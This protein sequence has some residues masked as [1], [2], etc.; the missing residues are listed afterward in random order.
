[1]NIPKNLKYTKEHDWLE[2]L[3][4]G[5]YK[6]G[7]T[8]YAQEALGDIVY[9]ELP[10]IGEEITAGDTL[11]TVESVKAVSEIVIPCDC[12]VVDKNDELEE[13]PE[14]VNVSC[15]E[16]WMVILKIDDLKEVI[17]AEEYEKLI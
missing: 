17:S 6:M 2:D 14:K 11:L 13:E 4:E 1:M 15:Y 3:G 7:I 10:E 5:K 12:E 8:E 16:S 9:I